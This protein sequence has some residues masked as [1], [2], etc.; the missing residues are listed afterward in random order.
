M[1]ALVRSKLFGSRGWP[2]LAFAFGHA[3]A[4]ARE[5][6]RDGRHGTACAWASILRAS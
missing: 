6:Q 4:G 1:P 3:F 2:D 5:S